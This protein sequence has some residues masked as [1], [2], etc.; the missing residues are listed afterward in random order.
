MTRTAV[1]RKE[2]LQGIFDIDRLTETTFKVT[3]SPISDA[4]ADEIEFRS[5]KGIAG[6]PLDLDTV[7]KER[8]KL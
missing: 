6:R 8:L 4:E 1:V 7:R 5:L 2:Q 3:I